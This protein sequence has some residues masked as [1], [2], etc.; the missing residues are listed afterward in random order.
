MDPEVAFIHIPKTGGTYVIQEPGPWKDTHG[1]VLF[2]L[3]Y[4]SHALIVDQAS[5]MSTNCLPWPALSRVAI[6]TIAQMQT[7]AVVRNPYALLVSLYEMRETNGSQQGAFREMVHFQAHLRGRPGVQYG[8][9]FM[10]CQLFRSSGP[11]I[12]DYI[13]R[14][15]TLDADLQEIADR[16]PVTYTPGLPRR[17][18][19]HHGDWRNYYDESLTRC[20]ANVWGREL[21]LFGYSIEGL[22]ES[23]S[24]IGRWVTEED[25]KD[26]HYDI[27][28]D[29]LS[30]RGVRM[31]R[32]D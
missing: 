11:L 2:P 4:L 23:K 7:F 9:E 3:R 14:Q 19:G 20:V 15:E 18:V 32:H 16:W 1:G 21:R 28:T 12:V 6:G 5:E 26:W 13:A 22:D 8:S 25:R 27:R 29:E 31:D 24:M 30:F 10:F 17:H